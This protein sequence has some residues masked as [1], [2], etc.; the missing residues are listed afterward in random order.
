[1][2]SS[3]TA[4]DTN[5]DVPL[6]PLEQLRDLLRDLILTHWENDSAI[7]NRASIALDFPREFASLNLTKWAFVSGA[8]EGKR[9][10]LLLKISV[11]P[12]GAENDA[13]EIL[14]LEFAVRTLK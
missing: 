9:S 8:K 14:G 3:L 4:D 2:T 5:Q 7:Q 6:P 10:Y 12:E 11:A 13:E 1:M